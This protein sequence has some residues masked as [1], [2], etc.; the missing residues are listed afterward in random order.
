MQERS[1]TV[2]GYV[3]RE[4]PKLGFPYA[5]GNFAVSVMEAEPRD[6]L[7]VGHVVASAAGWEANPDI[8]LYECDGRLWR[9]MRHGPLRNGQEP[10]AEA[11][12]ANEPLDSPLFAAARR[13]R[14]QFVDIY[15]G[16]R[17][18][19]LLSPHV[20]IR[21]AS[22]AALD[23][24]VKKLSEAAR[25][26]MICGGVAYRTCVEPTWVV[27]PARRNPS[28]VL[29]QPFLADPSRSGAAAWFSHSR[30]EGAEA[31]G[32]EMAA[33]RNGECVVRGE[34][35][36][37]PGF[38]WTFDDV[39]YAEMRVRACFGKGALA[40]APVLPEELVSRSLSVAEGRGGIQEA[41]EIAEGLR[42]MAGRAD[43]DALIEAGSAAL[44]QLR[45]F[46]ANA[47]FSDEDEQALGG[48]SFR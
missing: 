17:D 29:V 42:A 9:R 34:I 10:D 7:E 4:K 14:R 41:M 36:L 20:D 8:R 35:H 1:I 37:T 44:S 28:T 30:R 19:E 26:V 22:Q 47:M 45:Y 25:E 16:A 18:G 21:H 33:G 11:T 48:L 13:H 6:L 39:A 3:P 31:F 24:F 38:Q 46:Q 23:M 5:V 2:Q 32:R 27:V 40:L 12:I 43:V 15:K